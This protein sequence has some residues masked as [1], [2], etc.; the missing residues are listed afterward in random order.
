MQRILDVRWVSGFRVSANLA[1]LSTP[2][3]HKIG[4]EAEKHGRVSA[5]EDVA[6]YGLTTGL[7]LK[8]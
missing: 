2:N 3:E 8:T 4:N 5:A 7:L 1:A 6:W